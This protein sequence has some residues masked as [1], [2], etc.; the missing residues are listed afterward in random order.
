MKDFAIIILNWNG[1]NLLDKFLPFLVKY[2]QEATIY[3]ADNA[4]T[5]K[6]IEF[7]TNNFP[8]IKIIQNKENYGYANGY[9]QALKQVTEKYLCLINS[10]VEVTENWLKPIQEL[11]DLNT[12]IGVIQPKILD[13]KEKSNFEYAGAAGGFIDK[14]GY[15]FCRGRIFDCTEKDTG[16]YKDIF[17]IFWASGACFFVR[18]DVFKELNGFDENFFAHQEEID[19]C[20]R[21]FN[22]N[23]L[24]YYCG[25]SKVY[26]VG[27][28]TLKAS[29][30]TK[31]YFI[32]KKKFFN[33][34]EKAK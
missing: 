6:S 20:W 28:A 11:F 10:D 2:S 4:S 18:N 3:L 34:L 9:N 25:K 26:H 12:R 14:L 17:E 27:G 24:V 13:Y 29:N 8:E 19:F 16:Q 7:V 1:K 32:E 30:P 31:T 23:I 5:D 21:A 22:K 33:E 15:P